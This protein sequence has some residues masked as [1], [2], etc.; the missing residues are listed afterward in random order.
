MELNNET[1]VLWRSR[2]AAVVGVLA[3]LVGIRTVAAYL[4]HGAY[5]ALATVVVL[6]VVDGAGLFSLMRARRAVLQEWQKLRAQEPVSA[7][8]ARRRERLLA[9]KALQTPP[10]VDALMAVDEAE[11]AG[12]ASFGRYLV[13]ASVLIGLVGTFAGLSETIAGFAPVMNDAGGEMGT[14]L[15]APLSGLEV[16]FGASI[17]AIIAT[18]ALSLAAGDLALA[19]RALLARLEE[20]TRHELVPQ[21]FPVSESVA[22]QTLQALAAMTATLSREWAETTAAQAQRMES[23][24]AA[25]AA[26]FADD[27]RLAVTSLKD[28]SEKAV[29]SL[30]ATS[31]ASALAIATASTRASDA[32]TLAAT[33]ASEAASALSTSSTQALVTALGD[34]A[35]ALRAV[36]TDTAKS[37]LLASTDAAQAVAAAL[38]QAT[39]AIAKAT[40]SSSEAAS[41]LSA[42]ATQTVVATMDASTQALRVTSGEA[43]KTIA[44]AS[45]DNSRA[46]AEVSVGAL[47]RLEALTKQ[48]ASVFSA[49]ATTTWA[50]GSSDMRD[51]AERLE[52]AAQALALTTERLHPSLDRLTPELTALSRET[53]VLA[54]RVDD[55]EVDEAMLA[56]MQRLGEALG[57]IKT[58]LT[59][60]RPEVSDELAAE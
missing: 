53:A 32:I 27:A 19:E 9:L 21:I 17:V 45:A 41:L 31:A 38:T 43:A 48:L 33:L 58:L 36:S 8:W 28:V 5:F 35:Q 56:E 20:R 23:V 25:A 10:D 42:T 52:V 55:A 39:N 47:A 29:T 46:V 2:V 34:T 4:S 18:L 44:L 59:L 11:L 54:A 50:K 22:A 49:T 57:E 26:R 16:T 12:L 15:L 37:I 60:G 51:A 6:I 40:K 13:A 24:V 7:L 14:R 30:T 1:P 3:A